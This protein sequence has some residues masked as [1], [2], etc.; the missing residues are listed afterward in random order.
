MSPAKAEPPVEQVIDDSALVYTMRDL[1]QQTARIMDEIEKSG[2]PAVITRHGRFV[3][4]ISPL[5]RGQVEARVL[6]EMPRET[7]TGSVKKKPAH[8]S[9]PVP[10]GA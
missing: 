6:A 10:P 5:A 7:K 2:L 1:N 9:G 4:I 8:L 3:A